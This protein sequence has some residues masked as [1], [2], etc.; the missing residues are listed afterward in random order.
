[1]KTVIERILAGFQYILP[2]HFLSRLVYAVTTG[3]TT[4]LLSAWWVGPFLFGHDFMTDMKYGFRPNS[5]SDSFWDMFFPLTPALDILI[6]GLAVIGFVASIMRRQL[7]GTALGLICIVFAISMRLTA[8]I[9]SIF[10]V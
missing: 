4:I 5:S 3:V 10:T 9:P 2:Q 1:M 7:T 8:L 6:T